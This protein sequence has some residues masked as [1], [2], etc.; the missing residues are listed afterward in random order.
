MSWQ[1][2]VKPNLLVLNSVCIVCYWHVCWDHIRVTSFIW[3]VVFFQ[4]IIPN[5]KCTPSLSQGQAKFL[6]SVEL[7]DVQGSSST[8]FG[9]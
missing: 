8:G 2:R 7:S 5:A 9:G 4:D 3:L 6:Q 1:K